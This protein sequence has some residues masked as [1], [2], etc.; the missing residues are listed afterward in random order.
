MSTPIEDYALIGNLRTAALIS[1]NGS[2]DWLCPPRFD[3]PACFAALL[4]T[5][6]HG[7]WLITA[8]DGSA[9]TSRRRRPGSLVVETIYETPSGAVQVVDA[10]LGDELRTDV[11]RRVTG[12][13]GRVR[14]RHELVVRF[15]YGRVRP[16]VH[17][18]P[19]ASDL[20]GDELLSITAGPDSICLRGPVLPMASGGT[21]VG[22]FEVAQGQVMTFVLTW[23][24]S[25]LPTPE[26]IDVTSRLE[27]SMASFRGW[28]DRCGYQGPYRQPVLDSLAVLRALTHAGTGGIVAAATT[29]L[30]ETIGGSRNWDY[31]YCWLRDASL[32]LNAFLTAGY[33]DETQL[34]REWLLRAAAGDPEDLQIMYTIDGARRLPETQLK[35]LPGYAGSAPVRVGNAAYRQRQNDVFG[36]VMQALARARRSGMPEMGQSWAVQLALLDH[37]ADRWHRPDHGIW[38]MRGPQRRFTHSLAM[39][40]AAFDCAVHAVEAEGLEGPVDHWRATR[41]KIR[42]AVVEDALTEGGWYAQHPQTDEVDAALLLLPRIGIVSAD[43]PAYARTVRRIEETLVQDGLV[44]RYRTEAGVDGLGGSENTFLACSFWLAEAYARMGRREE[45]HAL[46]GRL[47]DLRNEVGLLAE[48]YDAAGGHFVGNVP[49]ALSHLALVDAAYA[50]SDADAGVWTRGPA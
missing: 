16:W 7:R 5:P 15:D 42:Q 40:W 8:D 37:L 24:P 23:Q 19:D 12:L 47:C 31:R 32:T 34:W 21:H 35:E 27:A 17:R 38:E 11:V 13:H 4:G 50:L 25:H 26:P 28:I 36:E 20:G 49:Q 46:M 39:V 29:S 6:D 18:A 14:M 45:A 1:R 9:P 48:E 2:I 44:R 10:M 33:R 41:D 43:D 3:A 22:D 30:P